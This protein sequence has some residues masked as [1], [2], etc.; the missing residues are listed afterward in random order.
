M[1]YELSPL[2]SVQGKKYLNDMLQSAS[3]PVF[4]HQAGDRI[5]SGDLLS[6]KKFGQD[7]NMSKPMS[8]PSEKLMEQI[9][10]WRRSVPLYKKSLKKFKDLNSDWQSIPTISRRE[11]AEHPELL[12]P[13]DQEL[14]RLIVYRTAG[15]TGHPL[16]VPHHP[17]AAAS[18][19]ILIEE[20]LRRCAIYPKFEAGRVACFLIGAQKKT[21]T[22]P[23]ILSVWNGAG[24][25][26]LNINPEDWRE[27][28]HRAQYFKEF[29]PEILTGDPLSFAALSELD[30]DIKPKALISTA[31]A[32]SAS[33]K[34]KLEKRFSAPVIDWYSLTET[35]PIGFVKPNE[36]QYSIL[37][38]DLFVEVLDETGQQS[39][40]NEIGEIVVSGGR[41]PFVP[42]IRYRT[43]DFGMRVGDQLC[44]LEGRKPVQFRSIKK[45]LI[46]T[47]D[48][49]RVLREY[50]IIQHFFK[51][52]A[53]HSCEVVIH[54]FDSAFGSFNVKRLNEELRELFGGAK[55]DIRLDRDLSAAC[56]GEKIIP[57]LSEVSDGTQFE[58]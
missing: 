26:K 54:P 17:Q 34:V 37:P 31:V 1:K 21:V 51:Q 30:L 11:I 46:N 7:L 6:L 50:P 52:R 5:E 19:Q 39:G 12:V 29:E 27:A 55:I 28:K 35:G 8:K 9:E 41:N 38:H 44:E 22:Y 3:A 48:I 2:I 10:A 56:P 23:C 4:N 18:Y 47:V 24:F 16:L 53:D 45:H 49:A 25:A 42:L 20:A 57:Y 13:D 14:K 43:G 58:E 33:L 36:E 15:T 32:M 40:E